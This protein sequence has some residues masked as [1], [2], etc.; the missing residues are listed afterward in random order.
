[1]TRITDC[2]LILKKHLKQVLS[3]LALCLFVINISGCSSAAK[4]IDKQAEAFNFSRDIVKGTQFNHVVYHNN[5]SKE[6]TLHVYLE[7]DGSPWFN[8]RQGP[9]AAKDPTPKHPVML[10]LMALDAVPSFYLG[11]PCYHGLYKE[12]HCN[13]SLW[14]TA[15]YSSAI[16]KSMSAVIYALINE[17]NIRTVRLFGFSGGGVLAVLI[18][19][20]LNEKFDTK[21]ESVTTLAANLDTTAW[22][23]YRGYRPL[24]DS[25]NPAE[26]KP[27][28]ADIRQFHLIGLKDT[29]VP[30]QTIEAYRQLNPEVQLLQFSDFDHHCCWHS[31]WPDILNNVLK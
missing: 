13:N 10:D 12:K 11:R 9:L 3:V 21:V 28:D 4:L 2:E 25:L 20:Q 22:T 24:T 26:E 5:V 30:H 18:A 23:Q 6:A 14:T 7:G 15:R 17:S 1:M 19:S 8:L 27:L 29:T 16:V 31:V